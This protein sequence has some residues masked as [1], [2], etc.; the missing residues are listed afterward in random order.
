MHRPPLTRRRFLATTSVALAAPMV[1]ANPA[2]ARRVVT[3]E[4]IT[5]GIIGMGI[6]GRNIFNSYFKANDRARV[7][8]VCDCDTIRRE[9]WQAKINEAYATTECAVYL[10][11]H[12]LL[13]RDDIDAVVIATPDHWHT[14]MCID[15]AIAG[16]DIYCEKPLTHSLEESRLIIE[17]VR[18]HDCV[19][20]TGSQQRT[21]YGHK[22]VQ[23]VEYVRNGRIG[24]LISCHVGVG[25]HP[26]PCDLPEEAPEPGLDWDRWL[27]PAPVRPYNSILSPRGV[28]TH[29]PAWRAYTEYSGGYF[30]DM[31]AHHYDIAQWG[32]DADTSGPFEV[33]PPLD[34]ASSRGAKLRFESG[35]EIHHGGPTGTTFVGETGML[36]VDR[37][38]IVPVPGT[39]FDTPIGEGDLHL[40]RHADHVENW[41]DCIHSR[42][43]PICGVEV[44]ARTSALCHLVNLAYKLRRPLRWDWRNWRFEDDA[45]AN[46]L[47]DCSYRP[48]YELPGV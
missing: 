30:A 44:G 18:A 22:F 36:H 10:D 33:L 11:Y 32:I 38:R 45:E 2:S 13:A 41:L 48:G 43:R 25:D 29:Y 15:A 4:Q 6:R 12:E 46:A 14:T 5:I 47:L 16:K 3:N 8:A 19:F 35:V 17:A 7:L 39:L 28:I 21:E 31:G 1:L 9:H 20:Q 26:I 23:A 42:K 24:K 37:G 34:P 40:P 27:G